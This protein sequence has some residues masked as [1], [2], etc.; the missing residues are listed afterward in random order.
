MTEIED[1]LVREGVFENIRGKKEI[2]S[3]FK[4][5]RRGRRKMSFEPR[6]VDPL[7]I[8]LLNALKQ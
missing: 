6:G 4:M 3:R 5:S 1:T 7:S 2:E 8:N